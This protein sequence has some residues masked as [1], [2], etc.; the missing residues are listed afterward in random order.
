MGS[1]KILDTTGLGSS[2]SR[3]R[4]LEWVSCRLRKPDKKGAAKL[5]LTQF[6][7]PNSIMG[8]PFACQLWN[9][10]LSSSNPVFISTWNSHCFNQSY[11]MHVHVER[12]VGLQNTT[13][14][15]A[16]ET[17][18]YGWQG[19]R[20]THLALPAVKSI[21]NVSNKVRICPNESSFREPIKFER[22][23]ENDSG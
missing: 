8:S 13:C 3:W 16:F 7:H 12:T 2:I 6:T 17:V 1:P 5:S 14:I 11:I 23:S 22:E 9:S 15:T 18:I 20:G 10:K 4:R 21:Q 19:K